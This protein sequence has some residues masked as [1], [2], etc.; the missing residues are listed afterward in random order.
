MPGFYAF[1]DL[2]KQWREKG[3]LDGLELGT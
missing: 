1:D 3:D 2:L